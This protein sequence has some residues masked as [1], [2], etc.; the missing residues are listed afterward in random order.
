MITDP[1]TDPLRVGMRQHSRVH[2][3]LV[4]DELVQLRGLRLPVQDQSLPERGRFNHLLQHHT[5]EGNKQR[6]TINPL[7]RCGRN[8]T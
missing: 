5:Q 1:E 4:V 2:Q 6:L 3:S 7:P 8:V